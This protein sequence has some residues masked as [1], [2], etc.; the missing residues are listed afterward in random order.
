LLH[1]R[2]SSRSGPAGH[3]N[4]ERIRLHET[5]PGGPLREHAIA[6]WLARAGVALRIARAEAIDASAQRIILDGGDALAYDL[7]V[8]AP[9]SAAE[10]PGLDASDHAVGRSAEGAAVIAARLRGGA[11]AEGAVVVGGGLTGIETAAELA[12]AHPSLPVTLVSPSVGEGFSG[13]ARR[14]LAGALAQLRVRVLEGRVAA[15]LLRGDETSDFS[16]GSFPYCVSL[17]RRDGLVEWRDIDGR[18]V[19]RVVTGRLGAALKEFI[20]RS[21]IWA[22]RLESRWPGR[23]RW[24][25]A[26]D[27]S[28]PPSIAGL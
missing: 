14:Y 7:L 3:G 20:C 26:P 6:P 2:E 10:P 9:G 28:G 4:L 15:A 17:G 25:E 18:P 27:E 19:R 13:N 5:A 11:R 12:E 24:P 8:Y 16:F 22:L 23:W 21:T 1:A